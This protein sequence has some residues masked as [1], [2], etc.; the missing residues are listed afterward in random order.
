MKRVIIIAEAGVNHNG[1]I[2]I[3]KKLIDAAAK[4]G[5][6]FVKFQSFK[7]K[8]VASK[9]AGK[10]QYQEKTTGKKES[11][12]EM[13]R[14]LEL[15]KKDHQKLL[16]YCNKRSI[17]FL[18]TPFDSDSIVLLKSFGVTIGKIPSG[19]ITNLPYLQQMAITFE[20]LILST[21]MSDLGEVKAALDVLITSGAEKE[22]ITILHC[23]T[24]YPTPMEDVN[25]RAMQAMQ[26]ELGVR[27]GYSDHTE[28]TEVAIAAVAL[29]ALIIEKHFTLD[30]K[31]KGPD[32]KASIEPRE[33]KAMVA[34]IRNIEKAMGNGI[35]APSPSEQKNIKVAR[36]SLVAAR[37]LQAGHV[38]EQEDIGIK[39]P[40]DGISPML[41]NEIKG[42]RLIKEVKEDEVL[43]FEHFDK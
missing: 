31:M 18:S 28:G 14:K 40:G 12:L 11:Q 25:L 30:R 33:L 37:N 39:R 36:K 24:E 22:K 32:H 43:T 7:A 21:G 13:L 15:S 42:K 29:G 38:I 9:R 35:K 20:E 10:A 5:A 27:V 16:E 23:T 26:K 1:D 3:A 41:I 4:A 17:K 8:N 34:A 6:D 19:E 2:K